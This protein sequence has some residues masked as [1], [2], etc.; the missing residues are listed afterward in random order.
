M[1]DVV[2]LHSPFR[3]ACYCKSHIVQYLESSK[4]DFRQP[5]FRQRLR[6]RDITMR[7]VLSTLRKGKIADGP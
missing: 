5:H 7:Q 6:D 4:V 3:D 1:A 2:P